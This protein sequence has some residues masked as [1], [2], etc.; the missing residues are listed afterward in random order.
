M[1]RAIY[2]G[3]VIAETDQF[4]EVE[5]NVYFPRDSLREGAFE[6]SD[7]T[8]VCGW[9]GTANYF[10][11]VVDGQRCDNAAW[12]YESPLPAAARIKDYVA[13]WKDVRVER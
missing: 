10:H 7:H 13:F 1:P 4:E 6:R 11:V 2:N 12:T 3:T 5:G 9:K 8:T